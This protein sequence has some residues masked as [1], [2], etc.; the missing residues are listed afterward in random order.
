[1][2]T[3]SSYIVCLCVVSVLCVCARAI[4]RS[5]NCSSIMFTVNGRVSYKE[6]PPTLAPAHT[7]MRPRCHGRKLPPLAKSLSVPSLKFL[8]GIADSKATSDL[9]KYSELKAVR[10]LQCVARR[11]QSEPWRL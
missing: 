11:C 4:S 3:I 1:M 8:H 10:C 5:H 9:K 2:V 7:P 6:A